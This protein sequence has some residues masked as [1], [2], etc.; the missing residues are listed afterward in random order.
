MPA[1]AVASFRTRDDAIATGFVPVDVKVRYRG[2]TIQA[3]DVPSPGA[4]G[5]DYALTV[6]LPES[7]RRL[8]MTAPIFGRTVTVRISYGETAIGFATWL[9]PMFTAQGLARAQ[10]AAAQ[11]IDAIIPANGDRLTTVNARQDAE[12]SARQASAA[13]PSAAAGGAAA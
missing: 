11:W 10:T 9:E 1:Q 2:A 8:A 13:R 5:Y 3:V 12:I 6:A 4:S 7:M